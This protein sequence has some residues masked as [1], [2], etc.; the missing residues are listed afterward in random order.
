MAAA[1]TVIMGDYSA[2]AAGRLGGGPLV[3]RVL[4]LMVLCLI[5]D[6]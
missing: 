2:V 4:L 1:D 5:L 3:V 6:L